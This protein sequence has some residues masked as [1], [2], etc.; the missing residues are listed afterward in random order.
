MTFSEL[1]AMID[2][3]LE[4]DARLDGSRRELHDESC[5]WTLNNEGVAL[6]AAGSTGIL[7]EYLRGGSVVHQRIFA[8]SPLSVDRIVN[9][10]AEHL[11]AYVLHRM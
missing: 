8:A 7:V 6:S 10:A 3:R 4:G 9:T 11:T 5:T 2:S 1:R